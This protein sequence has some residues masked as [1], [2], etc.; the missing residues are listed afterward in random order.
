VNITDT[1][2]AFAGIRADFFNYG[3][4]VINTNTLVRTP[5]RYNGD[6]VNYHAGLVWQITPQINVYATLARRRTSMAGNPM[7][8]T[9]RAMAA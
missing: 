1:V 3:L 4:D 9:A 2:V 5:Y 8:A 7:W 6:L